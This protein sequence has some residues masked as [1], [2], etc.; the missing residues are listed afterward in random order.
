MVCGKKHSW[1]MY[2]LGYEFLE[3][4]KTVYIPQDSIG[5]S[6]GKR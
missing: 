4:A 3:T 1:E 6:E 2:T 5:K